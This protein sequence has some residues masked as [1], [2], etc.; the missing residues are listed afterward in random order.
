MSRLFI[1]EKR[2]LA[3]AITKGLSRQLGLPSQNREHCQQVGENMVANLSGHFYELAAPDD[4]DTMYRSWSIEHLPIIPQ[5]WLRKPI[6]KNGKPDPNIVR[7]IKGIEKL[8]KH[9]TIVVNAGDP[10]REGQLLVDELLIELGWNPFSENTQ[11]IWLSS[12]NDRDVE[13]ALNG[14]F[15]N[16]EKRSLFMAAITRSQADW[17][18][19]LNMTRLF[20]CLARASGAASGQVVPVGRVQTPTLNLVVERDREIENFRPVDHFTARIVCQHHGGQ[21]EATWV[22]NEDQPGLDP[23]GRLIEKS[24]AD[25]LVSKTTDL[26]GMVVDFEEQLKS[27][28]PP[29]PFALPQLQT[30]AAKK[31][32]LTAKQTLEVAQALYDKYKVTTYPR[33]DSQYLP[34]NI[35]KTDANKTLDLIGALDNWSNVVVRCNRSLVSKCWNDKKVTDHHGIIPTLSV[36]PEIISQMNETEKAVFNL[37]CRA[38]VAQ[39]YPSHTYNAQRTQVE[40]SGERFKATGRKVTLDGWK[41]LYQTRIDADIESEA[42]EAKDAALPA[43]KLGDQIAV[44][45]GNVAA[46]RTKPPKVFDDGDLIDA[47]E[48]IHKYIKEPAIKRILKE[49]AGIGTGATRDTVIEGLIRRGA[50]KRQKKIEIVS[51]P[52][53]RSLIDILPAQVKSASLTALWEQELQK[54]QDGETNNQAFMTML[55]G[56]V[57]KMVNTFSAMEKIDLKGLKMEEKLEGDGDPCPLCKVG[58]LMTRHSHKKGKKPLAF[59]SC[60]R[61]DKDNPEES[62]SYSAFPNEDSKIEPL[63]GHGNPCPSCGKGKLVT[64]QVK[65]DPKKRFLACDQFSKDDKESCSFILKQEKP[66]NDLPGTGQPCLKCGTG[67]METKLARKGKRKGQ[68]FLTCSNW[69]ECVQ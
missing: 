56:E 11:R 59:L 20:T 43:M 19:G 15:P 41:Q 63:T 64:R 38:F 16:A 36:T 29:L 53:G 13:T 31:L 24:V 66:K 61:W 27:E 32:K 34:T 7:R 58:V 44:C 22:M 65:K 30:A 1:C 69:R 18:H 28:G 40:V 37:I 9:A 21:F 46:K 55:H 17:L 45:D 48:N 33:T 62:C 23:E 50:L 68:R 6:E 4:Y 67:V 12:Y 3:D 57:K 49:N 35:L 54:I 39:F 60:S 52:F 5:K 51:T 8:L 26:I 47:L 10:E 2:S 14:I 25:G 42:S